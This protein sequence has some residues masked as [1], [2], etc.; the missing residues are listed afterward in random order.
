MVLEQQQ[1]ALFTISDLNARVRALENRYNL[2]AERLLVVNQNMIEEYKKLIKEIRL[3]NSEL[4]ELR[5]ESLSTKEA[6]KNII[7]EME[8]FAKKDEVKV[9]ERYIEMW[10][11]FNF[12]TDEELQ[13]LLEEKTKKQKK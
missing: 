5:N 11:P 12:V 2:L 1:E 3:I 13:K 4:K 9:L 10:S 8:T 6:T 7:R